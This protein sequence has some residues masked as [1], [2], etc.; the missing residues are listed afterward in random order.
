MFLAFSAQFNQAFQPQAEI[1]L[2]PHGFAGLPQ[3]AGDFPCF[4]C[5]RLLQ[6]MA[7]NQKIQQHG[8]LY[9]LLF[10]DCLSRGKPLFSGGIRY[11]GGTLETYGNINVSDS[12]TAIKQLVYDE[13]KI[14]VEELQQA[15][16]QNFSG[17]NSLRS[18]L[19][20]A[21]KCGNDLDSADETAAR[22]HNDLCS[23]IRGMAERVGL[24]SY[25]PVLI[26]N[27]MNT[28]FG[29]TT[30]ASADGRLANTYMAN[31]NNPMSGMDKNGIT[32]MLN[33]L[34]K[35]DTKHHAGAV[36]NMRFS[37]EMFAGLFEKTKTLLSCYFENGG[38]QTMITVLGRGDLE[39][40]MAHP[41][42]YP[43][44]IVRVGGFS[45][46]FVELSHDV[47][48]ELLNRTLY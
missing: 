3:P 26:N 13:G 24:H 46:R 42:L 45:A 27:S 43:N 6:K 40:A 18:L 9:S 4:F 8:L 2:P 32:S 17:C 25:L 10:D 35:L 36:Q 19:L 44:L 5:S 31:A 33:S 39:E 34:V 48:L 12:L 22:F 29:V 1:F 23:M 28:T 15:L 47:Q 14:S 11:L 16:A 38:A 20:E 7:V 37:K 41:E 30:G 21:P